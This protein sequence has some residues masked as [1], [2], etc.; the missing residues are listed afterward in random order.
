MKTAKLSEKQTEAGLLEL[1][2]NFFSSI[3]SIS[4]NALHTS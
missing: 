1:K 3:S 4:V 2:L